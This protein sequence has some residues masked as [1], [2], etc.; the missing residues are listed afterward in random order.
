MDSR[1]VRL[2]NMLVNYSMKVQKGEKVL[3]EAISPRTYPLVEA[4]MAEVYAVGGIPFYLLH[5]ELIRRAQLLQATPEQLKL[6]ADLQLARMQEMDCYVG[7]RGH[8]NVLEMGGIPD[9][10]M[11]VRSA[12]IWKRVHLDVRVAKTR[13]V[14]MRWPN[15]N[16][17]QSAKMS[18][19][20]FEDFYFRCCTM[21]YSKMSVAMDP[22]VEL[23]NKT[24]GV[25]IS[26]PGT[27][28][29]FSI[30]GMPAIKC[31]G[32]INIPDG[33]V[34][35]APVRHS[36]N[37]KLQYNTPTLYD[38]NLFDGIRLE[39]NHGRIIKATC[40]VGDKTKLNNILDRDDGARYIGEF[41]LGCNPHIDRPMLDILFDEKISGSFH[42]T[43]GDAYEECDNGNKSNIHWDMVCRQTADVGGGE[44][45][46]DKKLVRKDG[47]FVLPELEA[48]NP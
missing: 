9:K 26:G 31:A 12:E 15:G 2:A 30:R 45:R 29:S 13:W 17:A 7:I 33:E 16:F 20:E 24:N 3:I 47:L 23:M 38:G 21:D 32:T 36:V 1:Y 39:F 19:R 14:V 48:L 44:I 42:F 43:P 40:E 11:D 8:D 34:F 28:L 18:T 35:T 25:R 6:E 4:L 41:A 27:D 10:V 22:L 5:D 46:F 37:G